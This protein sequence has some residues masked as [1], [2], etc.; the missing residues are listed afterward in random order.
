MAYWAIAASLL[1]LGVLLWPDASTTTG[2]E[3]FAQTKESQPPTEASA[4]AP[5][6]SDKV[7][8][9]AAPPVSIQPRLTR[10]KLPVVSVPTEAPASSSAE[11][12]AREMASADAF[13]TEDFDE[14]NDV[15]G[16]DEE[17]MLQRFDEEGD[18]A[19]YYTG[20][21]LVILAWATED[22]A[23]EWLAANEGEDLP[24]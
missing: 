10:E 7:L 17:L 12:D 3:Q 11:A 22:E 13:A 24:W 14:S 9:E 23:L 19:H 6:A 1:L 20:D 16:D 18:L 5:F 2:P 15:E 8:A 4:T 21:E